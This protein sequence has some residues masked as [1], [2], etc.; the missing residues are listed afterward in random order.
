MIV[1]R[2]PPIDQWSG[3][4]KP[5]D[6]FTGLDDA[7]AD[8]HLAADWKPLWATAK[9]MAKFLGWEGDIREGPYV[10]VLPNAPGEFAPGGII[11]AWKQDNNGETFL[12][13]PRRL[14]W[15]E[16]AAKAHNTSDLDSQHP[17]MDLL[18]HSQNEV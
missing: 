18:P 10:T 9:K 11:I 14:A 5:R 13:S 12:A 1:Y 8:S 2:I 16:Q 15:I 3:W 4:Q 7:D 17:K 6:V